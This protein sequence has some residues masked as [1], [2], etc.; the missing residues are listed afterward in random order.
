M[1]TALATAPRPV[2]PQAE[3]P[4]ID[5]AGLVKRYPGRPSNAL[6]GR[7]PARTITLK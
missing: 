2:A 4:A 5:V 7:E 1:N 6:D 3:V